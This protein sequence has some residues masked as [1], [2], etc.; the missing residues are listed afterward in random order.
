M[1]PHR[2][3]SLRMEA[4]AGGVSTPPFRLGLSRKAGL[5][6]IDGPSSARSS[7]FIGF[8]V[9]GHAITVEPWSLGR[10]TGMSAVGRGATD[11]R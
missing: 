11:V 5:L 6:C 8:G 9:Q 4:V 7:A 3:V 1:A 10:V 2:F